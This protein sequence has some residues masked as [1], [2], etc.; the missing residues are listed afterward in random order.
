MVPESLLYNETGFFNRG[1]TE[2]FISSFEESG[3]LVVESVKESTEKKNAPL[4][5]KF[6]RDPIFLLKEVQDQSG[7]D[8]FG[9]SGAL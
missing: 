7:E 9:D 2:G 3:E 8:I 1:D 6:G 4:L 5:C